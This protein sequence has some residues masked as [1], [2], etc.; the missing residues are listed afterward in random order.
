MNPGRLGTTDLLNTARSAL[1]NEVLPELGGVRLYECRMIARAMLIGERELE[2]GAELASIEAKALSELMARHG[3]VKM[4]PGHARSLL[5]GFIRKGVFDA[6]DSAQLQM[7]DA[8][9]RITRAR[10]AISNPKVLRDEP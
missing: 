2:R 5:A 4:T 9:M 8:L 10:L 1:L 6:A 7:R 3:L